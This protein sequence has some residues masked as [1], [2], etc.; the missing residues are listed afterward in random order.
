MA[1]STN[2]HRSSNNVLEMHISGVQIILSESWQPTSSLDEIQAELI[3]LNERAFS[4][5]KKEK[6]RLSYW[7][8]I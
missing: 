7:Q 8:T 6:K 5:K 2:T 4:I 3:P 1:L